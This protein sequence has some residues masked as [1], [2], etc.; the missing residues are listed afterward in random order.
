MLEAAPMGDG[1]LSSAGRRYGESTS[2]GAE[3][4]AEAEWAAN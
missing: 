4:A 2:D 3:G 1:P